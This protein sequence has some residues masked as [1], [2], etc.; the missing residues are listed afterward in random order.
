MRRLGTWIRERWTA[1]DV[2]LQDV[3]FYG[4]LALV[5]FAPSLRLVI[6]GAVLAAHA[7]LTPLIARRTP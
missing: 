2:D 3:H 1:L 6:V 5:A 7:W 4:G